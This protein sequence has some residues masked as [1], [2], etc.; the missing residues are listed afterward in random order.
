MILHIN[1][2]ASS[3]FLFSNGKGK[4]SALYSNGFKNKEMGD[5]GGPHLNSDFSI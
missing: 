4:T 1:K 2:F 5:F 3:M